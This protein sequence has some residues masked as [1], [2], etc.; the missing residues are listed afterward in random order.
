MSIALF[1]NN[2]VSTLAVGINAAATTINLATGTGALFPSFDNILDDYYYLTLYTETTLPDN[3]P[4]SP[5]EIVKVTG[6]TGDVLT[7][8][9]GADDTTALIWPSETIIALRIVAADMNSLFASYVDLVTTIDG[10]QQVLLS[11]DKAYIPINFDCEIQSWEIMTDT[12]GTVV[13][14]LYISTYDTFPTKTLI[15][16]V[17][18]PT[19][20]GARKATSTTGSF[21]GW[22]TTIPRGSILVITMPSAASLV[23][24]ATLSLRLKKV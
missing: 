12:T 21:T 15:S 16:D 6:R 11:G 20:S 2:A 18:P 8:E 23:T 14:P 24:M 7:V 17:S 4:I 1:T 22:I 3:E 13:F 9:R 19:C 5:Y 10:S